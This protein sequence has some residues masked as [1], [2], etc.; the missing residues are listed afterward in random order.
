MPVTIRPAT[1]DDIPAIQLVGAAAWRD[2]YTD[3]VPDGY[4]KA[5]I[6]HFWSRESFER[7]I[8]SIDTR[9]LVAER[10]GYIVGMIRMTATEDG[11]AHLGQ[12]YMLS[13]VR[14]QGLGRALWEAATA[15]MPPSIRR[16]RT[17]IV[18]GS[19]ARYFY[20]RLGF[21]VS[22]REQAS[23]RGYTVHLMILEQE[24]QPTDPAMADYAASEL[25]YNTLMMPAYRSA[26]TT[27]ALPYGSYGLDLGCGPG[28]L[29]PLLDEATGRSGQ[30][31][32]VDV[33]HPHL[34]AAKQ[35]IEAQSLGSRVRLELADLRQGL[36][37]PDASFDWVWSADV[38]WP[39]RDLDPIAIVNEAARVTRPGGIVALWFVTPHRGILLPGE[40]T[41]E[42][43]LRAALVTTHHQG[44]SEPPYHETAITWLR[45]AG[46]GDLRRSAHLAQAYAPLDP[47]LLPYIDGYLMTELRR[48]P[49][50]IVGS[51]VDNATWARWQR[52]SDPTSEE[53][54]FKQPDYYCIQ[55][56]LLASGRRMG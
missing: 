49:R 29:L 47:A 54:L 28:G 37:F 30:I 39:G 5:G 12:L 51:K 38:L 45:A 52:M 27:L 13:E 24:V 9:L 25:A 32:G 1:T 43:A 40:P 19:P 2:T 3:L 20:E 18:E 10:G 33:S 22:H 53:Y 21:K 17:A 16:Y 35:L 31:V 14:G 48:V 34:A 41:L 26:L 8:T 44:T 7:A 50:V 6:E 55:I 23:L 11:V 36:P 42:N 4:V 15:T 56:G 46:L